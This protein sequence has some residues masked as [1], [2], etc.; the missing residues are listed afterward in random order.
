MKRFRMAF[1]V[2]LGL[3]FLYPF[4]AEALSDDEFGRPPSM[5]QMEKVRRRIETVKMWRLT[6]ALDLDEKTSSRIIPILTTYDK[7]RSEIQHSLMENMRELRDAVKGRQ[8]TRLRGLLERTEQNHRA[9]E[10]AKEDE[11]SE[12]KKILT[13]EQQARYL[14]FQQEFNRDIK[15]IMAESREGRADVSQKE[16]PRRPLPRDRQAPER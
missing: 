11:W 2:V 12:L 9:L 4:C 8:D 6:S 15:R 1:G 10:R 5:E 13:V 16:R 7:K 3:F 14:I